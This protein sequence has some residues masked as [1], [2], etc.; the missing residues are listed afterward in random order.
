MLEP[1]Q[2][3]KDREFVCLNQNDEDIKST[4]SSS[5]SKLVVTG[6]KQK[7]VRRDQTPSPPGTLVTVLA[8]LHLS[9]IHS[10]SACLGAPPQTWSTLPT[11]LTR[12]TNTQRPDSVGRTKARQGRSPQVISEP[13]SICVLVPYDHHDWL[14]VSL[15][16]HRIGHAHTT[17]WPW[18]I[19]IDRKPT[20]TTGKAPERTRISIDSMHEDSLAC[21]SRLLAR[22]QDTQH[23]PDQ[24]GRKVF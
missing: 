19:M 12:P 8:S 16:P 7:P 24:T 14:C 15:F 11:C 4:S 3:A 9:L 20:L 1:V 21:C 22:F 2:C 10:V 23:S 5:K 13:S 17:Q 6:S 18:I